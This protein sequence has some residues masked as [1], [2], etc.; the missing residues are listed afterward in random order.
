MSASWRRSASGKLPSSW[1]KMAIQ[2]SDATVLTMFCSGPGD[3]CFPLGS[4]NTLIISS[5][6]RSPWTANTQSPVKLVAIAANACCS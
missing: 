3:L 6:N 2:V 1:W 4:W 5:K